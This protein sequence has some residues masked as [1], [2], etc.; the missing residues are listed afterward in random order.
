MQAAQITRR[1]E[2]HRSLCFEPNRAETNA[3]AASRSGD[4]D[5]R[6]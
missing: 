3:V 2:Q 4:G 6:Y 5:V 1:P